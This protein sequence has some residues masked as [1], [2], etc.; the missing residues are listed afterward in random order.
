ML[1]VPA[2]A[3]RESYERPFPTPT[4]SGFGSVAEMESI[5]GLIRSHLRTIKSQLEDR[6]PRLFEIGTFQGAGLCHFHAIAPELELHSLNILPSDR[7][8]GGRLIP[9]EII[10]E[11][12]I[13]RLA[14]ERGVPFTQHWGNSRRFD[15]AKLARQGLFDIVFIDG[16][17]ESFNVLA[18]T[19]NAL[20]ILRPGGLIIWHDY[21]AVDAPGRSVLAA[22][23]NLDA[24][25][26]GGSLTHIEGTW[27]AYV[28]VEEGLL[29][30]A[31]DEK[32]SSTISLATPSE[33][34]LLHLSRERRTG[35]SAKVQQLPLPCEVLFFSNHRKPD[36]PDD[37]TLGPVPEGFLVSR[38]P[39]R[40]TRANVVVFHLP[41]VADWR[42]LPRKHGQVWIGVTLEPDGYYP[43]KADPDKLARLDLLL[44]FHQHADH[45]L[46]Y[47]PLGKMELIRK[48]PPP[49]DPDKIVCTIITN[50]KSLSGREHLI[51]ALERYLPVHHFGPWRCNQPSWPRP[52]REAKLDVL[53]QYHFTLASENSLERNLVTEKWYDCLIA[54]CVPVY[55]GAPNIENYTP[56][57]GCFIDLRERRPI[58]EVAEIMLKAAS[59]PKEY[60]RFF[61]WKAAID[62]QFEAR[63]GDQAKPEDLGLIAQIAKYINEARSS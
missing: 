39:R 38:D 22:L 30:Q 1:Y 50:S 4:D 11:E 7:T 59:D 10:P 8:G 17:H 63:V 3:I 47:A 9:G 18:D 6:S 45:P 57:P 15:W 62:P 37:A 31:P 51:T 44:S 28:V 54:G 5:C 21:K 26:F 27:L 19:L 29:T 40:V 60:A 46:H 53:R 20:R 48:P 49:K 35:W 55:L 41:Q 25:E 12:Q 33:E 23:H 34:A 13:G 32:I 14:R 24:N 52:G 61:E 43:G 16:G 36:W 56:G 2:S 42:R 58:A